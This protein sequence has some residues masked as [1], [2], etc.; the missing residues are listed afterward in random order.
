MLKISEK[1]FSALSDYSM[2]ESNKRI[3]V[4]LKKRYPICRSK[5]DVELNEI[6]MQTRKKAKLFGIVNDDDIATT[7]DIITMYGENF[8]SQSWSEDIFHLPHLIGSEKVE[9]LKRRVFQ[10]LGLVL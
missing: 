2:L 5:S 9:L 7:L 6:I 1:S 8:W 3:L 10:Q 4:I